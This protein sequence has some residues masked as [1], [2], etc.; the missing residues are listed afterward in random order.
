MEV[1]LRNIVIPAPRRAGCLAHDA[2]PR[3][4][5]HAAPDTLDRVAV[6]DGNDGVIT[7]GRAVHLGEHLP[8]EMHPDGR[9]AFLSNI[10]QR[11]FPRRRFLVEL[12]AG[13]DDALEQRD[14]IRP[15][16]AGRGWIIILVDVAGASLDARPVSELVH[17]R[18]V[19][20]GQRQR[21]VL[22]TAHRARRR[23]Q[24]ELAP[25]G[26]IASRVQLRRADGNIAVV[27]QRAIVVDA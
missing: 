11:Q 10:D 16:A 12:H 23:L 2:P 19:G 14:A 1:A 24:L 7:A 20:V 8:T 4:V 26:Y 3:S 18:Q 5:D 13:A 6:G 21:D 9:V 22:M 17:Q 15:P 25:V 27:F